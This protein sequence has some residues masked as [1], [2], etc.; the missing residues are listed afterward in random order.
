MYKAHMLSRVSFN[1]LHIA[2]NS[3]PFPL[4]KYPSLMISLLPFCLF[5]VPYLSY[6]DAFSPFHCLNTRL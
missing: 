6:L 3:Q 1:V 4:P 5:Q 2:L